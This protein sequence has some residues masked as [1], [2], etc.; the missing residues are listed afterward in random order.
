MMPYAA[1]PTAHQPTAYGGHLTKLC[2]QQQCVHKLMC[3]CNTYMRQWQQ[4]R[5]PPA[6][7]STADRIKAWFQGLSD[8]T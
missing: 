2:H 1:Y 6:Y 3:Q 4:G 7:Q 8:R 5:D